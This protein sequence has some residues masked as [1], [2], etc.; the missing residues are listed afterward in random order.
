MPLR[1]HLGGSRTLAAIFLLTHLVALVMVW[2]SGFP[3]AGQSCFSVL[4][5]MS[6]GWMYRRHVLRRGPGAV[7]AL[8]WDSDGSWRLFD[9]E[10]QAHP[11]QRHGEFLRTPWLVLLNFR[12]PSKM[13][14][15]ALIP[16]DALPPDDFRRLRLRLR[17]VGDTA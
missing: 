11:V 8:Y 15:T 1:L 9:A 16:R 10:D 2:A 5:V 4:I 6:A 13:R 12:T 7:R 14:F 3:V 17:V